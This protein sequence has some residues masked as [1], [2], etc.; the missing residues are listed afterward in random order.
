MRLLVKV[1][2]CINVGI[3]KAVGFLLVVVAAIIVYEV[4]VRG[5][6]N[7]PTTW[8]HELSGMLFGASFLLGAGYVMHCREHVRVD[9]LVSRLRPRMQMF[10]DIMTHLL[11]VAFCSVILWKSWNAALSSLALREV[12]T[13][14]P[15]H[16]F[17]FPIKFTMV[18]GVFL[19][20]LQLLVKYI[21]DFHMLFTGKELK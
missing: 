9:I 18:L 17:L 8:A 7:I 15:W 11:A 13:Y 16:P 5:F 14:S 3:G 2:D 4:I 20:L 10:I 6:F 21:R 12:S 19:L 1:I